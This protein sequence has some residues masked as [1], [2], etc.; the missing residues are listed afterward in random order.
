MVNAMMQQGIGI[1]MLLV[2]NHRF[3]SIL[4]EY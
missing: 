1:T 4:Q 2:C 3:F